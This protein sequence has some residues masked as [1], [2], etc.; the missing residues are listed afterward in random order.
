MGQSGGISTR[1]YHGLWH[2]VCVCVG[3]VAEWRRLSGRLWC[4]VRE[5]PLFSFLAEIPLRSEVR[6]SEVVT[7][8]REG[9][10]RDVMSRRSR[11][12]RME[13]VQCVVWCVSVC[14]SLKSLFNPFKSL[15]FPQI[16]WRQCERPPRRPAI[17]RCDY[18]CMV[19]SC[20]LK[21]FILTQIHSIK[22]NYKIKNN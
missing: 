16:Q 15:Y 9:K 4:A 3:G 19:A 20:L 17:G 1:L 22:N 5:P 14:V 8:S 21:T 11:T 6:R 13:R 10:E 12:E 18:A 2:C 7:Y